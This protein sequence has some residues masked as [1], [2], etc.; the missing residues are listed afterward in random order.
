MS[1]LLEIQSMTSQL[2]FIFIPIY[3]VSIEYVTSYYLSWV[4][5]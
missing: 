3:I 1:G 2:V 5:M 4:D